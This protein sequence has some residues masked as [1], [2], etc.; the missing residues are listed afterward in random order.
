MI[1]LA[2]RMSLIEK[3]YKNEIKAYR[4]ELYRGSTGE[5]HIRT[6]IILD[7][8]FDTRLKVDELGIYSEETIEELKRNGY[9]PLTD[10]S[11]LQLKKVA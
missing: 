3:L 5:T 2:N 8:D 11:T 9:K 6:W 1:L 4:Y 10:E 7:D